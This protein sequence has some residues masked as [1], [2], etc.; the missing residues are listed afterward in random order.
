M[1][2]K[3]IKPYFFNNSKRYSFTSLYFLLPKN[4]YFRKRLFPNIHKLYRIRRRARKVA[5]AIS[6][7]RYHV[8][9]RKHYL[10]NW[11]A[12]IIKLKYNLINT[13]LKTSASF[14]RLMFFKRQK[15]PFG[16]KLFF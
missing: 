6:L 4:V 12:N 3:T 15:K 14:N 11:R 7:K 13:P 5:T 9:L 8:L 1:R 10:Y 16:K 2:K